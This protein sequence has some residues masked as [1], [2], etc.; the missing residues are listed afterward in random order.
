MISGLRLP[1]VIWRGLSRAM[2]R[3]AP[4][5]CQ[6]EWFVYGREEAIGS[7]RVVCLHCQSLGSVREPSPHEF[8]R[9]ARE[10]WEF[11]YR[12]HVTI[13]PDREKQQKTKRKRQ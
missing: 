3:P 5:R 13:H 11:P 4:E 10:T 7:L 1:H 9:A 6:H 2:P 12:Q 8:R